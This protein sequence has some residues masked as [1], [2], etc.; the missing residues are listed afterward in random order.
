MA[1]SEGRREESAVLDLYFTQGILPHVHHG[2]EFCSISL[3][4]GSFTDTIT[5]INYTRSSDNM[6]GE[7]IGFVQTEAF[8]NSG[9]FF[10]EKN[11]KLGTGS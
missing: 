10:E 2:S 3:Y 1:G 4:P 6:P 7:D 8:Y 9:T 5:I 11:S